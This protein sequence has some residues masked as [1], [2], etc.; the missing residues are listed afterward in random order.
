MRGRKK[1]VS[2]DCRLLRLRGLNLAGATALRAVVA[3]LGRFDAAR[4]RA[5]LAGVL[6]L[7][8]ATGDLGGIARGE[9]HSDGEH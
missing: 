1:R 4:M 2:Y 9:H 3:R 7:D 8:A 5:G 6:R